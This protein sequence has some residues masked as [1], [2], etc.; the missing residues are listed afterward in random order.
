MSSVTQTASTL[1]KANSSYLLRRRMI[2]THIEYDIAN[3]LDSDDAIA[4]CEIE[5]DG[6]KNLAFLVAEAG[7]GLI[8]A[9]TPT[10]E[11]FVFARADGTHESNLFSD[12]RRW[13]REYGFQF[14]L[15]RSRE[16]ISTPHAN[17]F[18]VND[19]KRVEVRATYTA[20]LG[21]SHWGLSGL[22]RLPAGYVRL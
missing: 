4:I 17:V 2:L 21:F 9:E 8:L 16:R 18:M 7:W 11:H 6:L 19:G 20:A 12:T 14:F 15:K 13:G 22:E 10:E 5:G 3:L 1:R